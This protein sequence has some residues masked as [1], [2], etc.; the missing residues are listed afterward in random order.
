[1]YLFDYIFIHICIQILNIYTYKKFKGVNL[2]DIYTYMYICICVHMYVYVFIYPNFFSQ[3]R[4]YQ[5]TTS[6]T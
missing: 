1:M 3:E 6:R 5:S 4:R 2:V